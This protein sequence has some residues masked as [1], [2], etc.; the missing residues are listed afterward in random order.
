VH[1]LLVVGVGSPDRGDDVAGLLVARLV[2]CRVASARVVESDGCPADL[3]S[4]LGRCRAAWLV[5]ATVSGMQPGWV[6]RH[7]ATASLPTVRRGAS[8]THG[9]GLAQALELARALSALP[10][11]VVFYGIEGAHF[12]R[13]APPTDAVVRAAERVAEM[14]VSELGGPS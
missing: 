7:D 2:R 1:D 9:L 12:T 10:P 3:V 14:V 6:V 4:E 5:D 8:S 11:R 13:G